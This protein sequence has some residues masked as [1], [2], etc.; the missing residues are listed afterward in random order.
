M[1][2]FPLPDRGNYAGMV[3]PNMKFRVYIE[4]DDYVMDSFYIN[5]IDSDI[6]EQ[7]FELLRQ[8]LTSKFFLYDISELAYWKVV[9]YPEYW[10]LWN[11]LYPHEERDDAY[12]LLD[13]IINKYGLTI[14]EDN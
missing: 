7:Q 1:T 5:L 11:P 9:K 3:V 8:E 2:K 6:T 4:D 14:E 12:V 13:S 10:Y